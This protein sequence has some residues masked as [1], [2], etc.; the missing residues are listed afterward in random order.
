[1]VGVYETTGQHWLWRRAM[2]AE[3]V[4]VDR[5]VL[6][7]LSGEFAQKMAAMEAEIYETAGESFNI[8]SPKQLGEIL[9]AKWAWPVVRKPKPAPRAPVPMCWKAWRL[10]VSLAQLVLGGMASPS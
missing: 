8:A 1:M 3:E 4:A 6:S 5:A 7:R 10:S 2:E 9:F